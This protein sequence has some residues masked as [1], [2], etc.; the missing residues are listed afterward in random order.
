MATKTKPKPEP[1][2][3]E[4]P[5][6]STNG[7]PPESVK[8]EPDWQRIDAARR[9]LREA[10]MR[11]V[12]A[13]A[14]L[15]SQKK[16]WEGAAEDLE[17][18]LEEELDPKPNLFTPSA[19]GTP[20]GEEW[21]ETLIAVLALP[22]A[23][24]DSLASAGIDTIGKLADYTKPNDSGYCKKL[25]D[26]DGIGPGKAEKIEQSLEEFWATRK[27]AAETEATEADAETDPD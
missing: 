5:A 17:R 10:R 24:V 3:A 6:P 23:I 27:A 8:H 4:Q 25:T 20:A 22:P 11:F 2:A 15:K 1:S 14:E 19:N 9:E 12:T 16:S 13:Q 7:T 26:I 18:I 21:R